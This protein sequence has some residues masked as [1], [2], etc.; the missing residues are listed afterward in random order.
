MAKK[1]K[2]GDPFSPDSQQGPQV[3]KAQFD[4]VLSYINH[5]KDEGAK[6]VVGGD[7]VGQL[8]YFVQPTIFTDVT[9]EMK[10]WNEEIFGPVL[11]VQKV[12]PIQH[13]RIY[14]RLIVRFNLCKK[15]MRNTTFFTKKNMLQFTTIED[16]IDKANANMYGLACGL[17]TKSLDNALYISNELRSGTVWVNCYGAGCPHSPFGGFKVMKIAKSINMYI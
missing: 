15:L 1:R 16:A 13:L 14:Y 12:Y 10:I 5:G 4:K 3:D 11:A 17:V 9:K 8:G 2:V 6:L 7:R